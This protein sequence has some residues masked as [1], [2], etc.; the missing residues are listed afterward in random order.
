MGKLFNILKILAMRQQQTYIGIP[1]T[2]GWYRIATVPT[3]NS[4]MLIL[5]ICKGY[6]TGNSDGAIVAISGLHSTARITALLPARTDATGIKQIRV[7]VKGGSPS[8]IDGYYNDS[9]T[10][11]QNNFRIQTIG[12]LIGYASYGYALEFEKT[13]VS[14]A[15]PSG[16]TAIT[17]DITVAGGGITLTERRWQHEVV[18]R[19]KA[20]CWPGEVWRRL[21]ASWRYLDTVGLDN[22][23][24]GSRWR[25]RR[26]RRR[27]NDSVLSQSIFITRTSAYVLLEQLCDILGIGKLTG[28][29]TYLCDS[30]LFWHKRIKD[31]GNR[32]LA[33]NRQSLI[34]QEVA[35]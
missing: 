20:A 34:S 33:G 14:A 3:V 11:Y 21:V 8:Y 32:S 9:R 25:L 1:N 13:A 12:G 22:Y 17:K 29:N 18:H 15:I 5:S 28:L 19:I 27:E 24:I 35:A 16:Y 31:R 30:G 2:P 26:H 10:G 7:L 4:W 23:H 6:N